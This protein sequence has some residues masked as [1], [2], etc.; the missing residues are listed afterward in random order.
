MTTNAS[1]TIYHK[2]ANRT[3]H[4]NEWKR[5]FI[6]KVMWQERNGVSVNKGLEKSNNLNAYIPYLLDIPVSN[7]DII[8]K[9]NIEREIATQQ[10]LINTDSVFTITSIKT[11][12]YGSNTMKHTEIIGQ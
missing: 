11:C 4:K 2:V 9:G 6:E 7:G 1:A 8:V 12:D 3:T 10:D 5:Y